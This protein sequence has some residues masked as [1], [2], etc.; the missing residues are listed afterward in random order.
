MLSLLVHM[1]LGFV[2]VY[3]IVRSNPAIFRRPESGPMFSGLELALLAVGVVS[4]G[5]GWTFNITF[6][7]DNTDGW[8]TNP[9]WGDGSWAQYME[10]I[11]DNPASSSAAGD[12]SIANVIVLPLALVAGRHLGIQRSWLYFVATLFLSF[13]FG[14]AFYLATVERQRRLG[15]EPLAAASS[16]SSTGGTASSSTAASTGSPA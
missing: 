5:V 9:L 11:F 15:Q 13:S 12:F 1:L 8:V 3:L 16:S 7:A 2:V 10:L 4:V 6:V 14:W